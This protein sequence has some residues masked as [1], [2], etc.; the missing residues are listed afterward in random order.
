MN[1]QTGEVAG[2]VMSAQAEVTQEVISC[3]LNEQKLTSVMN[4]YASNNWKGKN[5]TAVPLLTDSGW[6]IN[7]ISEDY[8][9]SM[10]LKIEPPKAKYLIRNTSGGLMPIIGETTLYIFEDTE[11]KPRKMQALVAKT[12]FQHQNSKFNR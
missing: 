2:C 12:L 10:N 5:M 8:A 11:S 7:M 6:T 3:G 4:A 9:K 1:A